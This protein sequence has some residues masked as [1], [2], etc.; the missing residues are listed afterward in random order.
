MANRDDE[1][2]QQMNP[3]PR[4]GRTPPRGGRFAQAGRGQPI[5][6]EEPRLFQDDDD[7][8]IL[9]RVNVNDPPRD[10]H[11]GHLGDQDPPPRQQRQRFAQPEQQPQVNVPPQPQQQ[12]PQQQQPP[13]QPAPPNVPPQP[14]PQAGADANL[15]FLQMLAGLIGQAAAQAPPVVDPPVANPN[16]DA[17]ILYM[18][19]VNDALERIDIRAPVV[20]PLIPP[21]ALAGQNIPIAGA[22]TTRELQRR[23]I[24]LTDLLTKQTILTNNLVYR[25]G[26]PM[27]ADTIETLRQQAADA[28]QTALL[29]RQQARQQ[30]IQLQD[31]TRIHDR[32]NLV[33]I[34]PNYYNV[35]G[36]PQPVRAKDVQAA[37]GIFNPAD[38]KSDFGE[39]WNMLRYYG[40]NNNWGELQFQQ[41]T[42]LCLLGDARDLYN[43]HRDMN[44]PFEQTI[45]ALYQAYAK[46]RSIQDDKKAITTIVRQPGESITQCVAKGEI[47]IDKQQLIHPPH[48]WPIIRETLVH[49]MVVNIVLPET[50][51]HLTYLENESIE[52]TGQT[53]DIYRLAAELDK[54]ELKHNLRPKTPMKPTFHSAH[55]GVFEKQSAAATSVTKGPLVN[56]IFNVNNAETKPKYNK[57]SERSQ[58]YN[59]PKRDSSSDEND[60]KKR[61]N[62]NKQESDNSDKKKSY[63]KNKKSD[64]ERQDKKESYQDKPKKKP[65][66]KSDKGKN[67]QDHR[68]SQKPKRQTDPEAEEIHKQPL[69]V[70]G[71]LRGKLVDKHEEGSFYAR[72]G[73]KPCVCTPMDKTS[74]PKN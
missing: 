34:M 46:P 66:N 28:T 42:S 2:M 18:D 48:K 41:A 4:V 20:R 39:I 74:S 3:P 69:T 5:I 49:E 9:L 38:P 52:T 31:A 36:P 29:L 56:D 26:N 21:R 71:K 57:N 14:Q 25:I 61:Y 53:C 32:Y 16:I 47:Q 40:Q 27:P 55:T 6:V 10:P 73:D 45:Q 8:E 51:A 54:Y 19:Q 35:I 7:D 64:D 62:K 12:A 72:F 60:H 70:T 43:Q 1:E 13:Q 50:Q 37:A 30:N 22:D 15:A 65:Y 33:A 24:D 17:D 11:V 68:Q 63:N 67:K 23:N 59:K 58:K 44:V